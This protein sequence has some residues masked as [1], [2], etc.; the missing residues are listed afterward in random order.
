MTKRIL[1]IISG[2]ITILVLSSSS[3]NAPTVWEKDG[4]KGKVKEVRVYSA[5][6]SS[7]KDTKG[8]LE[9]ITRYDRN[10]TSKEKCYYDSTGNLNSGLKDKI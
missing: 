8:R 9:M 1:S 4:L 7:D 10:G 2:L 3:D 6:E 5:D